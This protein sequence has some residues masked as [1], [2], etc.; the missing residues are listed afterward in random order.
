MKQGTIYSFRSNAFS[1]RYDEDL[2][3][4][5]GYFGESLANWLATELKCHNYQPKVLAE[6]W[7]WCVLLNSK[8]YYLWVGCSNIISEEILASSMAKPPDA[9]NIIWQVFGELEIPFWRVIEKLRWKLGRSPL[10]AEQQK[11]DTTLEKILTAHSEI[12]FCEPP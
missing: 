7:G 4:N 10:M 3:T 9:N 5:P 12:N 11:L 6:D 8:G 1:I 2:A